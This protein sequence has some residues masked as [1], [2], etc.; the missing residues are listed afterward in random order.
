MGLNE[1]WRKLHCN[2]FFLNIVIHC[3]FLQKVTLPCALPVN[4][5][6]D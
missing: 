1:I 6:Q 5:I 2:R 3:S 4:T